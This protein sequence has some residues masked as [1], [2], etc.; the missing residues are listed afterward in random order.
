MSVNLVTGARTSYGGV[1]TAG[2]IGRTVQT[3]PVSLFSTSNETAGSMGFSSST[4]ST[5]SSS[6]ASCF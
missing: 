2:S 6:S 4:P 5:S 1:E 3:T